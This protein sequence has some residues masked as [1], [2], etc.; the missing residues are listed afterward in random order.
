MRISNFLLWQLSYTEIHV[1]SRL[2][3]DFGAADLRAAIADFQSRDRRF[4]G[5]VE[6]PV[7]TAIS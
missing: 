5:A 7:T 4:G 6:N 1:T 2:W 3:P